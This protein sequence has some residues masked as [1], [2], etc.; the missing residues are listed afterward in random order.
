MNS[1]DNNVKDKFILDVTPKINLKSVNQVDHVI[2]S[3]A[4]LKH[5]ATPALTVWGSCK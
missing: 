3:S 1:V 4:N 5:V 2:Q